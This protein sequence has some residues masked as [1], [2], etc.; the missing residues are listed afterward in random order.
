[1]TDTLKYVIRA[2]V[3]YVPHVLKTS[4]RPLWHFLQFFEIFVGKC[5]QKFISSYVMVIQT[6]LIIVIDC[7]CKKS[8]QKTSQVAWDLG[9]VVAKARAWQLWWPKPTP[10]NCGGQSP[11]LTI[12]VAKTHA[13]QL[14]WPKPTPDNCGG[15]SSRLTVV[16]A[17]ARVWQLWWPK[18]TLDSCGGQSPRL[19]I[20]SSFQWKPSVR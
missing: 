10:D 6:S 16:V 15:Q 13:W 20:R 2:T 4:I 19:T 8:P 5:R 18:P 11:R 7:L 17:K 12:V 14:W 1:M 9:V 3:E